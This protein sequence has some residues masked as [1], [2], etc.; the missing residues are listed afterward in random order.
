MVFAAS[1]AE[2]SANG[3]T[4]KQHGLLTYYFLKK[5]KETRGTAT[6]EDVYRYLIKNI[7]LQSIIINNKEQTPQIIISPD[8]TEDWK[9]FRF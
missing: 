9:E 7:P 5:L 4:D 2:Q 8:C 1:T 3:Y 6:Y